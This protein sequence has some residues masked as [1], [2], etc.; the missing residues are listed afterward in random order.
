MSMMFTRVLAEQGQFKLAN[1][2]TLLR[3]VLIVPILLLLATGWDAAALD[4]YLAAAATDFVDGWLARASGLES[5]F[6]AQLD[7][8]VDNLFAVAILFFLVLAFPGLFTRHPIALVILFGGPLLYLAVS[9]VLTGRLL[10]FH[11]WSAKAGALMLFALW[12]VMSLTQWEFLVPLAAALVGLSR[13]EQIVFILRGGFDQDAPHLFAPVRPEAGQHSWTGWLGRAGN[14][15]SQTGVL[16]RAAAAPRVAAPPRLEGPAP[17]H[18]GATTPRAR[19]PVVAGT[20]PRRN[21]VGIHGGAFAPYR[22]VALATGALDPHHRPDLVGTQPSATIGPFPQWSDPDAIVTLDP[23]GHRVAADFADE[24]AQGSDIRPSIAV[25]DGRLRMGEILQALQDG[26]LS[27]DARILD[28]NGDIRVTKIAI[29][30]V[31]YLPGVA[32]RLGVNEQ[33]L[34]E[35]LVA[36]SGGMYPDLLALQDRKLFLPPIGGTS[37][38]LFGDPARLGDSRTSITCRLHD[39]CNGS[40]VFGSDMCTCRPYLAFGVEECIRTAQAGG[41]GIIAYNRK[42]GRSL[43]EVVKYLV[44]NA[45]RRAPAGDRPENYFLRTERIAGLPDMREQRLAVDVLH[46]LG[47]RRV[48]RWLSMSNLKRDAL[49]EAGIEIVEQVEIPEQLVTPCA[50]VEISAKTQAGYYSCK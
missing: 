16:S 33:S 11:F 31:W 15:R 27:P 5:E 18:W 7:S 32:R 25:A 45:R 39:E 40:D 4:L 1:A 20:D 42:E 19:G 50:R 2:V 17:L 43:G 28:R 8:V 29:E 46:W 30:P 22:G 36:S 23:W 44:Y 9:Q 12:P 48:D 13:L 41:V 10:M 37:V 47:V 6:G 21:S 35:A 26:R 34:R 49:V 38:Y 3:G 24:I 14:A